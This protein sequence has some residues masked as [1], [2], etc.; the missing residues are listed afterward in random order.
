[1]VS[2]AWYGAK[3]AAEAAQ[4]GGILDEAFN[5]QTVWPGVMAFLIRR[6]N[7]RSGCARIAAVRMSE[8]VVI[9]SLQCR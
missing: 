8:V 4:S 7:T 1:L 3:R 9:S 2:I 6:P 5:D